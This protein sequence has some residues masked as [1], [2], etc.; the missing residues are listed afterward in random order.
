M[1]RGTPASQGRAAKSEYSQGLRAKA[2]ALLDEA[3]SIE[4]KEREAQQERAKTLKPMQTLNHTASLFVD[5]RPPAGAKS[6][7]VDRFN[8]ELADAKKRFEGVK[9]VLESSNT[10]KEFFQKL[11]EKN[12][13]EEESNGVTTKGIL[14]NGTLDGKERAYQF[15]TA[16]QDGLETGAFGE[17]YRNAQVSFKGSRKD[18]IRIDL[19][20]GLDA[21]TLSARMD[22]V[23]SIRQ[24]GG[25][26]TSTYREYY[27][28]GFGH[29]TMPRVVFRVGGKEVDRIDYI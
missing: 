29:T 22:M 24:L 10:N 6:F 26:M 17:Q 12:T 4:A 21:T 15:K 8:R 19:P 13:R 7:E 11:S 5:S 14:Y 23:R 9:E 27:G 16:V 20:E 1:A 25:S 28:D 2:K 18:E 3:Q